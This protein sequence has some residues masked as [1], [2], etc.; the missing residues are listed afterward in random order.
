[1]LEKFGEQRN[2]LAVKQFIKEVDK[3]GDVSDKQTILKSFTIAQANLNI[4]KNH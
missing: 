3:D 2:L 4:A 1:M